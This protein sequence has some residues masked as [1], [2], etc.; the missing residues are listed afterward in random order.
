MTPALIGETIEK[1]ICFGDGG[2][3]E[4]RA[5]EPQPHQMGRGQTKAPAVP[6]NDNQRLVEWFLSDSQPG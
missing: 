2:R 6:G 5:L 1:T 4:N 3:R